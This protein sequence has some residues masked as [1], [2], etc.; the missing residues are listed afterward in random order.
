MFGSEGRLGRWQMPEA[1]PD[2]QQ[3]TRDNLQTLA[4]ATE[5]CKVTRELKE[6]FPKRAVVFTK[7]IDH[8]KLVADKEVERVWEGLGGGALSEL[9][10][11]GLYDDAITLVKQI[12]NRTD[13][14]E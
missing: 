11:E 5:F 4:N 14:I 9:S 1:E 8:E 7:K 13:E 12:R 2:L 6:L 10:Q 3:K